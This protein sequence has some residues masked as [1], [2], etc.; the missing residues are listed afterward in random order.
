[1]PKLM[2]P[3]QAAFLRAIRDNPDDDLKRLVYADWLEEN[4]E[5]ARSDFIRVQVELAAMLA[6][7]P[8]RFHHN[9][10]M[11]LDPD[12]RDDRAFKQRVSALREREQRL[13][14]SI[15]WAPALPPH[16]YARSRADADEEGPSFYLACGF[17]SRVRC[18][19]ADWRK[20][21]RAIRREHP[22][23]YVGV[24]DRE[25]MQLTAGPYMW[26]K[27]PRL[28][29]ANSRMDVIPRDIFGPGTFKEFPTREK[30]FAWL[31]AQLIAWAD[32]PEPAR[33]PKTGVEPR[34]L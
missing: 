17:A 19:F 22:V 3:D 2:H 14:V 1:M 16:W 26:T 20:Y 13:I 7:V 25:P 28:T 33:D 32:E 34:W 18:T 31:S 8:E 11:L 15:D 12:S 23:L 27:E 9:L 5:E 30:A 21:G 29:G 24:T 6:G 10:D 4:G